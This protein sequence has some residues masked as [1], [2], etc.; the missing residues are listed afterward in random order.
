[1]ST[2]YNR[3]YST[4]CTGALLDTINATIISPPL[5]QIIDDGNGTLTFEFNSDLTA[6]QIVQFDNILSTFVCPII[7]EISTYSS[8]IND[9]TIGPDILWSSVKIN[10]DLLNQN[11]FHELLDVQ[12]NNPQNEDIPSFDGIKWVNNPVVKNVKTSFGPTLDIDGNWV[13]FSG[14]NYLNP[15]TNITNALQL[16]DTK[17]FNNISGYLPV[18]TVTNNYTITLT[19]LIVLGNG[20]LTITLPTAVGNLGKTYHIKNI[21]TQKITINTNSTETVDGK[22]G[23][24]ITRQYDSFMIVSNGTSWFVI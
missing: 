12:I 2:I 1:M 20:F 15:S 16:I 13:G 17:I 23:I 6:P 9:T 22:A 21:G 19:D 10:N 14:T 5:L 24:V 4:L 18:I 8:V 11:E 3:T 7:N